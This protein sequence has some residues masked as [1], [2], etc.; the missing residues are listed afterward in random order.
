MITQGM[1]AILVEH[2]PESGAGVPAF[3]SV[4]VIE[5]IEVDSRLKDQKCLDVSA[6]VQSK[7][8]AIKDALH[9][10]GC[11][12]NSKSSQDNSNAEGLRMRMREK[13]SIP[14]SVVSKLAIE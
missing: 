1:K 6:V 10:R 7:L 4:G 12:A 8:C 5:S 14:M 2:L 3:R 9:Y 11:H 13:S